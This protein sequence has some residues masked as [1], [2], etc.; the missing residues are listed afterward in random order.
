M[1]MGE[2]QY[3]LERIKR[4]YSKLILFLILLGLAIRLLLAFVPGFKIDIT[5]WFAWAIRLSDFNFSGFYSKEVF[6]DYTPGYLYVLSLLG[7]LKNLLR[8]PEGYFY[9]LLKLPAIISDLIICAI[10][11]KEVRKY[12]KKIAIFSLC[13]ILFN[14]VIIFNS[15]VWGQIDSI[16]TLLMLITVVAL[17][18]NNL[19]ISSIFFG[20][21][22]L[23]K[24]QALALI[25]L[26]AILLVNHFKISNLFKLLIPGLLVTFI[27]TFPFFP[28]Q[29]FAKLLQHITNTANEYSYTSINAYNFWGVVGFWIPDNTLWNNLSYQVWGYLLMAN[30]WIVI[31]YLYLR[32]KLSIYAFAA[33]A[34]LAF[35]FLPTRVHERYLYPAIVFLILLTAIY[36]SKLLLTLTG[37]L[38]FLH[39]LNLYYVYVYYNEF[40]LKLP[41]ILYNPI[42]YNFLAD[43]SKSL[44]LI[45]AF[46]FILISIILFKYYAISKKAQI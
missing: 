29:T 25:P 28:N 42:F 22:L 45:S 32:K 6:T 8:I 23:V 10:I 13:A 9:I 12:S 43:N 7:F 3:M 44:S 4:K 37:I 39:F 2:I 5:D 34:T 36:K 35:F 16:L 33:L 21:A 31:A 30:Y 17:N 38:S 26:L 27:L 11:Y 14:P 40:Y 18:R 1:M 24:P 19:I 41:K 46:I 15:S 20:L